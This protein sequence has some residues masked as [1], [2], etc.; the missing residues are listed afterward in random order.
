[1]GKIWPPSLTNW[2]QKGIFLVIGVI[3]VFSGLQ[4]Y[5]IVMP[6]RNPPQFEDIASWIA[7]KTEEPH[8]I[9]YLDST[10]KT[11]HRVEYHINTKMVPHTYD[12]VP[13]Y[14]FNWDQLPDKSIVFLEPDVNNNSLSTFKNSAAYTDRDGRIIGYAWANT[15]VNLQPVL[16]FPITREKF[17]VTIVLIFATLAIISIVLFIVQIKVTTRKM[18][19]E[20]GFHIHAEFTLRKHRRK[21]QI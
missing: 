17:P 4:E 21:K 13:P 9:F 20:P 18:T 5:F 15:D 12:S 7:W 10:E 16:P 8:T 2:V 6:M 3:L 14:D 11:P 19:G 1:M